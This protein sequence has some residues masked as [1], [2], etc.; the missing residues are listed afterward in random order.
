LRAARCFRKDTQASIPNVRLQHNNTTST[1][2][3]YYSHNPLLSLF[4]IKTNPRSKL[5]SQTAI[6]AVHVANRP[7]GD[8]LSTW[9]FAQNVSWIVEYGCVHQ[10]VT[11]NRAAQKDEPRLL[12]L[13]I[14]SRSQRTNSTLLLFRQHL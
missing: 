9:D 8:N 10:Q 3:T 13:T 2:G 14:C 7:T 6:G 5:P 11:T 12:L 4:V 1:L